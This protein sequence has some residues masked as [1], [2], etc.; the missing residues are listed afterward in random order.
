MDR[1]RCA[2]RING[3]KTQSNGQRPPRASLSNGEAQA[4]GQF[5]TIG[6]ELAG[7]RRFFIWL[8]IAVRRTRLDDG[9]L[10]ALDRPYCLATSAKRYLLF[11][12]IDGE[13]LVRKA[14]GHRLGH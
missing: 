9:D 5:P 10:E 6:I 2:F 11:N 7:V 4:A 12:K 14:S 13:T 1:F 3:E 8:A